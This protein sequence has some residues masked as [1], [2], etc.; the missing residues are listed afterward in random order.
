MAKLAFIGCGAMGAPMAERLIGAGH[1]VRIY[2]PAPAAVAPLIAA[3]ATGAASPADAA[4]NSEVA[5]ACLPSPEVSR[6]VAREVAGCK[7]LHVY[8]EMSTIG[9]KAIKA[10][11]A[12]LARA[13]IPVLDSP[14]SG[15]PRG[16]R[17]GTLS[18]MVA[19]PRS[20]FEEVK[21]LL[22]TIARN[23]FY[24]GDTPGL[25]QV[26]KLANNMISAAGMAAAFEASAMAV[27]AGV[28]ARVL[29]DTVN[30]S[31]GRNSAT[32]DKFPASVLTRS[33]DYGGKLSTMYKDVFLCLEE[34]RELNVPM[35]VGSNV[36]QLWF[37]A[38]TQGRGNDDYTTLI[39]MIEDWAGVIVGGNESGPT[40][41]KANDRK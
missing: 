33:F 1:R 21:P 14:V 30:A 20:A 34:A 39:K 26:T 29:I 10:I 25:G 17:A 41:G 8:V 23:V 11:A 22:E 15:G 38:M 5:F 7:G 19:G 6:A 37:H 2:D 35:W 40:L 12:D 16:A 24:V 27:K 36:V 4:A 31:T 13:G 28:D 18:T 3:G 32:M 9:S